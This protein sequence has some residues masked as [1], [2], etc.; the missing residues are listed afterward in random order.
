MRRLQQRLRANC[1]QFATS[2]WPAASTAPTI[3]VNFYLAD[4]QPGDDG[5][6]IVAFVVK[7]G[8]GSAL[9][10]PL[11]IFVC[12]TIVRSISEIWLLGAGDD[13]TSTNGEKFVPAKAAGVVRAKM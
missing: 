9:M 13:M 4:M 2:S 3:L 12:R 11:R 6:V 8:F 7:K 1:V 5:S 10:D